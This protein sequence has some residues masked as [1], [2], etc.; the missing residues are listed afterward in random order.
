MI[1][2]Y[3][4]DLAGNYYYFDENGNK[5]VDLE[6]V[7][8]KKKQEAAEK[9]AEQSNITE[10]YSGAGTILEKAVDTVR[11]ASKT[12]ADV[13]INNLFVILGGV[14]IVGAFV[15]IFKK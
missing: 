8:E 14:L 3:F 15:R 1:R 11:N 4:T 10:I 5:V 9:E 2:E 6:K 13:D 12:L 7:I